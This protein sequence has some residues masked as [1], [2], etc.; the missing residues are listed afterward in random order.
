[1]ALVQRIEDGWAVRQLVVVRNKK[2]LDFAVAQFIPRFDDLKKSDYEVRVL[3]KSDTLPPAPVLVVGRERALI[4]LYSEGAGG[5][6]KGAFVLHGDE[7]ATL[8]RRHFQ[9]LW[10]WPDDHRLRPHET[11]KLDQVAY[12]RISRELGAINASTEGQIF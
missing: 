9:T 11:N 8:A 2:V 7:P 1:M 6:M 10:D 4:G 5:A 12:D 3:A